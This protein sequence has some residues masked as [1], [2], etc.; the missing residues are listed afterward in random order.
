MKIYGEV[1]GILVGSFSRWGSHLK[2][3]K[4]LQR[5][6]E[7]LQNYAVAIRLSNTKGLIPTQEF[8]TLRVP[9]GHLVSREFWL[10]LEGLL[11][12][13]QPVDEAIK[14]SEANRSTI[15]YVV[16]RWRSVKDTWL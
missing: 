13:L 5:S 16:K 8:D 14:T 1:R 15:G 4:S 7:A 11:D 3:L 9:I 10:D 6:K 12:I 2:A